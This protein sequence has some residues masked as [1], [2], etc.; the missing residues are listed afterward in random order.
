M[1][2]LHFLP[3]QQFK[4]A[5]NVDRIWSL[6]SAQTLEQYTN[7]PALKERVPVIDVTRSGYH[8]V[9]GKGELINRPV[10]VKA[11]FFSQKAEE[12]I[13]SVGGTCVLTA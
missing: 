2:R 1:R 3:H 12:K 6:V 9:L 4:P 10:I 8:K 13:K 7:N 5:L 11:R